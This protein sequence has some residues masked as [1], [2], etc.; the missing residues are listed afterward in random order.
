MKK[1]ISVI[2]P[3]KNEERYLSK[4]LKFLSSQEKIT[5]LEIIVSISP[6]TTDKTE[7][8]AR[9][10]GARI[11]KGGLP[12]TVRNKGAKH[13]SFDILFFLDADTYSNSRTFL[14]RALMEFNSKNLDVAGTLLSPEYKG[15]GL[16]KTF[17]EKLYEFENK[18]FVKKENSKKPKMQSGMFV[19]RKAFNKL[20]GFREGLFGEDSDFAERAVDKGM[21]F[22][23]L[24]KCGKLKNSVRRYEDKGILR[25]LSKYTYFNLRAEIGGY[26]SLQGT[27]N[28]YFKN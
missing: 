12:A 9:K 27:I 3:C 25:M 15:D 20:N 7:E 10:Y 2:I 16:K 6:D 5:N 28:S 26:N 13:S 17:Y 14:L 18:I 11:V 4:I 23:I 22:G 21:N 24:K 19:R 1:E 8:I